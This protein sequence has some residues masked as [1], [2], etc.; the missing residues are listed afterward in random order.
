M[1]Q[2]E[3]SL[4]EKCQTVAR[5][6]TIMASAGTGAFRV[7]EAMNRVGLALGLTKVDSEVTLNTVL[8]TCH[9]NV[10]SK[11]LVS[12]IPAVAVNAG[13]IALMEKMCLHLGETLNCAEVNRQLDEIAHKKPS[14]G[15]FQTSLAALAACAAFC[16]LNNG[17]WEECM[18]AGIAAGCGHFLRASFGRRRLNQ[19]GVALLAGVL[20]FTVYLAV[21]RCLEFLGYFSPRHDAG[22]T[23]AALFLI[24]GFPLITAALDMARLDFT[25]GIPRMVYALLMVMIASIS[26]WIVAGF[27]HL[28][29]TIAQPLNLP[30][31]AEFALR[32]LASFVGVF[33]FASLFNTPWRIALGAACIGMLCN[34]LRLYL[35]D[36]GLPL[37]GAAPCATLCV[38][39]LAAF[40]SPRIKCPRITLSVP[41]VLIMIPGTAAYRALVYG[42]DGLVEQS[43]SNA[44]LAVFIVTGIVI[45]LAAAR[46]LTD[47]VWVYESKAPGVSH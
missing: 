5:V 20:A 46:M 31:A 24:P 7:R 36:F 13:R 1:G 44:L 34:T 3:D 42:N 15:R 8:I 11:T 37:Q 45:G 26:A 38:G 41:A 35:V 6:G 14:Y 29:P 47:K 19:L 12:Q 33:G 4:L 39:L 25:A 28:T 21:A 10:E 30:I 16:F 22:Y 18:A 2:V 32:M 23:S 27:A 17:S 9:Q 40:L 43:L